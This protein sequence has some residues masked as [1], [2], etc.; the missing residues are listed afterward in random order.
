MPQRYILI[1]IVLGGLCIGCAEQE[2]AVTGTV[3]AQQEV[4]LP[5]GATVRVQVFEGAGPAA[6]LVA[7]H[8]I[9][10]AE[11]L[12]VPFTVAYDPEQIL[13][14]N[15]YTVQARVEDAEGALLW[16]STER[17]PVITPGNPSS[18]DIVVHPVEP[19]APETL[20]N[21]TYRLDEAVDGTV[22]LQDGLY[23]EAGANGAASMLSVEMADRYATGDLND[24]DLP[25][26]AVVL[27]VA[28]GGS[29]V[30]VYL[31]AVVNEHGTAK[32]AAS[33][34]LGD[35][36]R[37]DGVAIEEDIIAVD[38]VKQGPGDPMAAPT[39][40]IT[41]RYRLRNNALVPVNQEALETV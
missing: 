41:E 7:E 32:H 39:Q 11:Q 9:T 19:L 30:F 38:L 23:E 17:Y 37:V 21:M 27:I 13:E 2:A 6:L 36:V 25:D 3:T 20:R 18:V 34:M 12:P 16:T 24:D 31:A 15:T 33:T 40:Q 26:A 8:V 14:N 10:D 1:F 35:R 5:P 28:P 22:L 4:D 29:G